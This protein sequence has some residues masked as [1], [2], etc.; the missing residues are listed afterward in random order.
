[1]PFSP[2]LDREL[3]QGVRQARM[4]AFVCM[5]AAPAMYIVCLYSQ[6][7]RG[8]WQ[9]FLGGFSGLPWA[10][11]RVPLALCAAVLALALALILPARLGR[12]LDPRSALGVLKARNL[13]SSALM[14][15]VA[16]SGLYLGV[17]IGPPAASLSLV[18]CLV[19][20]ARG[21]R[22]FPSEAGW[23]NTMARSGP[24]P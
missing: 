21:W 12:M 24:R 19:P 17:K 15:A 3:H 10:D 20:M 13:V 1:M 7:F 22:M 14:V 18:L 5:F 9:L 2:E 8:R 6:V 16:I 11:R 4:V 23:R